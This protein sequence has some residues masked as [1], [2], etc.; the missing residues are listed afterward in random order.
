[1]HKLSPVDV[2]GGTFRF[3]VSR[4]RALAWLAVPYMLLQ[5]WSQVLIFEAHLAAGDDM[6]APRPIHALAALLALWVWLALN[7]N[8]FRVVLGDRS[9]EVQAWAPFRLSRCEAKVFG[10]SFIMGIVLIAPVLLA[11]TI[12]GGTSGAGA[13]I[14]LL[15]LPVA[16][17]GAARLWPSLPAAAMG[18]RSA[19]RESLALTRGH[20][21]ALLLTALL[22]LAVS[23]AVALVLYAPAAALHGMAEAEAAS[24][25]TLLLAGLIDGA[26][27]AFLTVVWLVAL[28]I[29]YARLRDIA[30]GAT[31]QGAT[32]R[33]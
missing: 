32:T 15:G 13:L 25:L 2:L 33:D 8:V 5:A 7:V 20:V 27:N 12:G 26:G 17:Y 24:T 4:G 16:L 18:S 28:A 10:L 11:L 22:L 19:L 30:Q 23:L 6:I 14:I 31:A 9:P 29:A 1:M 3:L 21:G